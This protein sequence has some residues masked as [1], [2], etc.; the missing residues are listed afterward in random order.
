MEQATIRVQAS[1]CVGMV[2]QYFGQKDLHW[3]TEIKK[4][5]RLWPAFHL[6]SY[7]VDTI[8]SC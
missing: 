2:C 7:C 4:D 3:D 6:E 5:W 8:L 1:V